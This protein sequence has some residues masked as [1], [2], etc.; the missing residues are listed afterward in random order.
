MKSILFKTLFILLP[1]L[2][3]GQATLI[4]KSQ[5]SA[6]GA[7]TNQILKWN[8]TAWVFANDENSGTVT[9][10]G[11]S[12]QV[13]FWNGTTSL[14][15]S[16]NLFWDITNSRLG[17]G[18]TTPAASSILDITST[19]KGILIPRMTLAQR[20][21]INS[22]ATGLQIYNTN[23]NVFQYYNGSSWTNVGGTGVTDL[24]FSGSSS[25][26]TL[27][28]STGS[29]VTFVAGTNVSLSQSSNQLTI[30]SSEVDGSISNEGTLG[31][32]A[33]A[34]N[35]SVITSNTS[36][37]AGVTI[38]AST[39]LSIS[40]TTSSNG[41]TIVLTNS[42]PDQTVSLTG[43][44][45][46]NVT[47]T[48]PNFTITS[49]EVDGSI[50]NEIQSLS[51]N[52]TAGNISISGGNTITLNVNDADASTTN[53]LQTLSTAS[54]TVSLSN[55]GGSFTIAGA[56]INT[57]GTVGST[58]TVTGTEVDGST[59]NEI[60][61]LSL[62]GQSL[63]ISSGTGV[64]LP[65]VGITAGTGIS[66]SSTSGTFTITNTA[67]NVTTNLTF[68][69]TSSPVT[70]NS[71]DGTDVSFVAGTNVSLSQTG[72][73]LTINS[74]AMANPMI[75]LGDIIY[76]ET[77]GAPT[78]L[79]GNTAAA[80]Y[81]LSQTG[82]GTA[83]NIPIWKSISG[84]EISGA[85]LT[86]TDD[87]N[88]TL[89]LGG[90]PNTALLRAA[91]LT[92]GWT[93]QLAVSRGGTGLSSLGAANQYLRVNSGATA[94]EYA[95]FPT[96][97]TDHGALTGLGDDDHTQYAMLGGRGTGQTLQGGTSGSA[98]LQ[99][100]STSNASKGRIHLAFD[101]GDVWVGGATTASTLRLYNPGGTNYTG[102]VAGTQS[103]DITYTLPTTGGTAGQFLST[104]GSGILSWATGATITGTTNRIPYYNTS[105][106]FGSSGLTWDNTNSKLGI[107]FTS[108]SATLQVSGTSDN[109]NTYSL[110]IG[111]QSG[112]KVLNFDNS[113]KVG[114]NV[115]SPA[116][117]LHFNGSMSRKAPVRTGVATAYTVLDDDSW[118]I[119]NNASSTVTLTLPTAA[120]FQGRELMI[121]NVSAIAVN[122]A[123]SNVIAITTNP[124]SNP[125]TTTTSILPATAGKWATLVSVLAG[126]LNWYWAIMQSN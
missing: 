67:P 36:G 73:A 43:A 10:T 101:G 100:S 83:S 22:P 29:D 65:V 94:L 58:I 3:Y 122:S 41:G 50:T 105:S 53:E 97:I 32:A 12:G 11:T 7:S 26:V 48:Y 75:T 51:T 52:G 103:T 42:S 2:S 95:T 77:S 15:G 116:T 37:A 106:S 9:G 49:T 107:N 40:E 124:G 121:K 31:V 54:N 110:Y 78:R 13:S 57:V 71:S 5:I 117:T 61:N 111:N 24:T 120:N 80:T 99:L 62:S 88:V 126:D 47:G 17:I 82:T 85:A 46:S 8:G 4:D 109:A 39:G 21:A 60:Q 18:T 56:G 35:T 81:Y 115:S 30:N 112:T 19:T 64:T 23:S 33:G 72:N 91:S 84:N 28:S 20:D 70:L 69:G 45:I 27:N 89:T 66:T 98:T 123:S 125:P 114:I 6:S 96:I 55:S 87:T 1:I 74:T 79:A 38:Q 14:T 93:G 119:V 108:P 102:L 59:T 34:A 113:G 118:I 44:G 86:K 68:S 76:G 16:N 63:G 25:P 104:N 90:S 92:L